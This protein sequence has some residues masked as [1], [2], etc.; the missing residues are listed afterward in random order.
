MP[1]VIEPRRLRLAALPLAHDIDPYR[2]AEPG[3]DEL[4]WLYGDGLVG[5]EN[6]PVPLLA[7]RLPEAVDGGRRYRYALR[8]ARWHD[9]APLRA[10]DIAAAF[11]TVRATRWGT[12]RPYR[13]VREVV[14]RDERHFDVVLD[15]PDHGFVRSF[16]GPYGTPALPVLRHAADGTPIGTGPF[17]LRARPELGRWVF[18]PRRTSPRGVAHLGALEVR[19]LGSERTAGVML[20]SGE[21]DIALPL[22]PA[23]A[24]GGR[25]ARVRRFTST[26][27]LLCNVQGALASAAARRAFAG[28]V[29]VPRLQRVYVR[30]HGVPLASLLMAGPNDATFASALAPDPTAPERLR[31]HLGQRELIVA[32]VAESPAHQR[33]F[34]YLFDAL[35]R[36]GIQARAL[37]APGTVYLGAA[38]PLRTGRFDVAIDGFT[39]ADDPD[40]ASDWTCA[41]RPPA[42]GNFARWCDAAFDGAIRRGDRAA[43]LRRLYEELVCI[44]LA[45]AYED[46][47][48]GPRVR[49]FTPPAPLV[50]A[51]Y[52]CARWNLA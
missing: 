16:F 22:T 39:Y 41:N 24:A 20:L 1:G 5:W 29:D 15:S 25:F 38:G 17:A 48:V 18:E 9:G 40:L 36:A 46:I 30:Q 43:A 52:G 7:A 37:P 6:G 27:V 51:T 14:V 45:R 35:A 49:G 44:P 42:G 2:D 12:H 23:A 47:G 31:R 10:Q 3:A 50:V 21:A 34:A 11:A 4:A 8:E 19:L 28:S 26:A 32:Y 33:V 13:S